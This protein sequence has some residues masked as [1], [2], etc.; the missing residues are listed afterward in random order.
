[1]KSKTSKS[2]NNQAGRSSRSKGLVYK[3]ARPKASDGRESSQRVYK[4]PK[5]FAGWVKKLIHLMNT[6]Y[7]DVKCA[8]NYS[9]PEELLVATILSAQCTDKRVNIVT[10]TLF[11]KYKVPQDLATIDLEELEQAIKSTGFYKN[12]AKNIKACCQELVKTYGGRVP[13]DME[14]LKALAG[15]GRKTAN[16]V[17]GECFQI[18]DGIVVDTHVRRLSNRFEL[19]Q[20]QNPIVIE[21]DLQKI[22]PPKHWIEFSHWLIHHGRGPCKSQR[23]R[24]EDCFLMKDC[25][26]STQRGL[27]IAK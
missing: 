15:V 23:P 19:T 20:S 10:E 4:T 25:P 8:L 5:A 24:C 14:K 21:K 27:L 7:P 18:A 6:Y 13:P 2:K 16:V 26:S 17:L 12:K 9:N 11:K 3:A 22:I 1:M